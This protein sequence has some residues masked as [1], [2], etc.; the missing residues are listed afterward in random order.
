MISE[1][2]RDE[3]IRAAIAAREPAYAPYSNYKVGAALLVENGRIVTGCNVENVSYGL[4]NCAE[5][6]AVFKAVSE[7]HRRIHAVVVATENAGSPC[8][9]CRQVLAEFAGDVP[10]WLV[11][12]NGNGRETTLH[13]L[14]PDHFGP[15]HLI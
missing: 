15:E 8:G 6:T 3:L 7:G 2:V 10:V 13:T 5:R 9:A 4:T 11:D 1:A 12:V 14:L